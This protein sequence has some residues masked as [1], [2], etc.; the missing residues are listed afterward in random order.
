[1]SPRKLLLTAIIGA[2]PFLVC[3][4]IANA[5]TPIPIPKQAVGAL[6]GVPSHKSN[7]FLNLDPRSFKPQPLC[8]FSPVIVNGEPTG[9]LRCS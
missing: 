9:H 8:R 6:G 1:M 3:G 2:V 5:A 4:E 7:P